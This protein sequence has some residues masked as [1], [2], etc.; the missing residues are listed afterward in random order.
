MEVRDWITISAAII[1][2]VG[3]FVNAYINRRHEIAKKRLEYRMQTLQSFLLVFFS[4]QKHSNPFVDDPAFVGNLE[5]SRSKFQIYGR[6]D[7]IELFEHMVKSIETQKIGEF[8][9][10]A[11]KLVQLVRTRIREEICID[12]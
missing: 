11:E 3:W 10:S 8:L 6:S 12:T 9:E 1:V 4:I 5:E 2:V 7:E